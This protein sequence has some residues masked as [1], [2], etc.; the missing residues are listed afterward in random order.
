MTV[1]S[2]CSL[3]SNDDLHIKNGQTWLKSGVVETDI[4]KY[5]DATTST[6]Q[7]AEVVGLTVEKIDSQT[8][9]TIY[10]RVK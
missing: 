4:S 10:T 2:T 9:L 3:L 7:D 5:P 8:G 1:N 6:Y